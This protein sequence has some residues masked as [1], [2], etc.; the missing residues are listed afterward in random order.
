LDLNNKSV[1]RLFDLRDKRQT[2]SLTRY[3][4][5]PDAT[6]RY[7]AA[8]SFASS[9]DTLGIQ[10]L[11][12][13]LQDPVEEVRIAAAFSLGQ[14][15]HASCED[16]LIAAFDRKDSLSQHQQFNAVVLEAIGKCGGEGSLQNIASVSTYRPTDTLLLEGQCRAIYR[17]GL[18]GINDESATE[19]M[20]SYV[21]DEQIPESARLMAAHYLARIKDI[22]PDSLQ[23]IQIA[24]AFVRAGNPDI[25][26]A[27]ATALGKS[28]TQPAFGL[29]SKVVATEQDWRVKCNIIRALSKF[30]YDTVR[31]IITPQLGDANPH[32]SRTA[33]DYF[34]SNGRAKDADWYWRLTRDNPNLSMATQ[35]GLFRASN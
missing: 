3:L 35:I 10:P 11:I 27:L 18:R 34:V 22:E 2:D 9:R 13:L 8:L 20:V 19:K 15:G 17:F 31:G 5:H 26:M 1:Q 21:S 30:E 32:I 29:L 25:R 16:P 14:I 6:L 12:P 23:T 24:A 28:S 4:V 33:A 7:I